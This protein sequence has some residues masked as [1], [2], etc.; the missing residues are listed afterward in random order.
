MAFDLRVCVGL[1]S[2]VVQ[3]GWGNGG[4]PTELTVWP[5]RWSDEG[6]NGGA[7]VRVALIFYWEW[8]AGLCFLFHGLAENWA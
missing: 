2:V 1:R 7:V 6:C 4:P 5:W 8:L 3:R